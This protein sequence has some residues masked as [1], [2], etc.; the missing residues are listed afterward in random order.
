M[1]RS[2]QSITKSYTEIK[3]DINNTEKMLKSAPVKMSNPTLLDMNAT[4]TNNMNK[5]EEW[6]GR[7]YDRVLYDSEKDGE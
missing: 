6:S 5:L 1:T 2:I 4:I 3:K 7:T